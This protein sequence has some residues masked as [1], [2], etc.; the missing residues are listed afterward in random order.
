MRFVFRTGILPNLFS[1]LFVLFNQYYL[2]GEMRSVQEMVLTVLNYTEYWQRARKKS[3]VKPLKK[4]TL[5][6][7]EGKAEVNR[8]SFLDTSSPGNNEERGE[9]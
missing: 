8:A 2:M 3:Y 4:G 5:V 9:R 6:E 1:W 7:N